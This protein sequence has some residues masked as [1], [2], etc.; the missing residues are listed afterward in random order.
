MNN[1]QKRM[2]WVVS[3]GFL[4]IVMMAFFLLFSGLQQ[5]SA[6]PVADATHEVAQASTGGGLGLIGAGIAFGLAALGAGIAVGSVGAAALGVLSEKPQMMGQALI[7]V[8]LGEGIVMF[9]FVMAFLLMQN[10]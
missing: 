8:A 9:G 5:L 4:V 2:V 7:F 6:A 3:S 1:V 10:S